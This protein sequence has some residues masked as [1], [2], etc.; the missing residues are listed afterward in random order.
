MSDRG[1]KGPLPRRK[2]KEAK[3]M[4]PDKLAEMLDSSAAADALIAFELPDGSLKIVKV[5]L[6]GCY[7]PETKAVIDICF[8]FLC[9]RVSPSVEE[10]RTKRLKAPGSRPLEPDYDYDETIH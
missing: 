7:G 4:H 6:K 1:S 9:D 3:G 10:C 8:D 5:P 2:H